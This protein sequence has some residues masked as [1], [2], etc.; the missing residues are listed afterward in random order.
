MAGVTFRRIGNR[1]VPIK[2]AANAIAKDP[3]KRK[4]A[5]AVA[6]GAVGVSSVSAATRK[7]EKKTN[8]P[9][10]KFLALGY[11]LQIASGILSGYPF[12]GKAGLG[13]NVGGSFTTDVA[14]T[15]SFAKA[16]ASMRG[17]KKTKLK[18]YA[19]HQA[20]GTGIGYATF[21]AT[22]LANPAVRSKLAQWGSK[23]I[24]RR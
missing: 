16:T 4:I 24:L 7:T 11:G 1:I 3:A 17:T 14:S 23:L 21:G 5:S 10:K 8:G 13:L 22:L 6:V 20:I 12:K 9:D 15:A 19:K 2:D 18:E